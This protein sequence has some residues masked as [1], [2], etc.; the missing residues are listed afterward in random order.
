VDRYL[1]THSVLFLLLN[2]LPSQYPAFGNR[3]VPPDT[4][5]FCVIPLPIPYFC[6]H[7]TCQGTI[8]MWQLD[9]SDLLSI[10]VFLA[11]HSLH[12]WFLRPC[13][14]VPRAGTPIFGHQ[15]SKAH[16]FPFKPKPQR[17]CDYALNAFLHSDEWLPWWIAEL[18]ER[19][20]VWGQPICLRYK[21]K[22][23]SNKIIIRN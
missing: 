16:S 7:K 11:L 21:V 4:K 8:K 9:Q 13:S 6:E 10:L 22:V 1:A 2:F 14:T 15:P 23:K 19:D 20:P 3:C 17:T 12:R 5:R 18:A